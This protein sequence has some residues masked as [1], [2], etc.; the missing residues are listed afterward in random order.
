MTAVTPTLPAPIGLLAELTHRCPLRCPY[1][2]NPLEL[3]KRSAELDTATWQRVLG[4]AAALGVLHVHL[5]GGEP[6]ARQD[7]VEITGACADLGLYSNLIT[8]GVGGAL[9]KLDALSEAGLDHVQLSIQAAEAGNAERIGGLRNAQ[10]QKFAFAERV[11]ALG[12]PLTLNAVIHRGNIDEVPALIDLAVRLGAKRLEV[13][14]TQYY[15]WAYVNRAALMPAK[16]DVDRSIRVVEEARERLKGRLVIDLVVPDYYAKYPKACA[17][18]WGR[19]LMNVTPSGKVLPCHAAETIP[20]LA[21]WNVQ[22]R[23]LGDIWANSPAFQAY[24]GTSWMKEPC[25]SCDRRE[26]DWG[27]CRCQALALAGDA[28]ATDPACSLSPLHAKVQALAVAE[29]ALE[30]APDYQYRTIGGA[31]VVPQPEGVSA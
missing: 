28:A 27:G 30:T 1:C 25:R 17:G 20:G 7:I 12:L 29:S 26:K 14:H 11:V 6:T 22:E 9:A 8:S 23:A 2:S 13:A 10:P 18:G 3:D 5:S 15:G 4:E 31:P 21:F 16:P 19:R 24:R